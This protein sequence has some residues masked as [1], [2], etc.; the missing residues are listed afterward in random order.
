VAVAKSSKRSGAWGTGS[1]AEPF[2][3]ARIKLTLY[4]LLI[5]VVVVGFLSVAV[6]VEAARQGGTH[7]G[8][9]R[10]EAFELGENDASL[11]GTRGDYSEDLLRALLIADALTVA[12][13][14]ALSYLLAG[15]TLRPIRDAMAAQARFFAQAAH[16]LRTPLAVMRTQAEVALDGGE[17]AGPD[18]TAIMESQVEEIGRLSA[19]VDRLLSLV[20]GSRV[21]PRTPAEPVAL[22]PLAAAVVDRLAVLAERRGVRVVVGRRVDAAVRGDRADLE[23]ALTNIV[24]NA[25]LYTPAGGIV[26]VS[27][28]R[29]A[30]K[31]EIVTA[32]TGIGLAPQDVARLG[33]PFFRSQAAREANAG[34][35]G[36]GLAIAAQIARDHHG[37]FHAASRE[38]RGTTVMLR[39]PAA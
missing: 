24:E 8:E 34:G 38:G 9:S 17:I 5:L 13:A 20:R 16:D 35:T 21:G 4:Y 37:S 12:V 26:D 11:E 2:S 25:I 27:V 14:A 28:A 36:L 3:R 15:R 23:R 31:V 1:R 10:L 6:F 29:S 39:F 18:A 30:G 7:T 33:E 22:A 19:L 32:D